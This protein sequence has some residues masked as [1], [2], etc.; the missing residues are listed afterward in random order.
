VGPTLEIYDKKRRKLQFLNEMKLLTPDL[1]GNIVLRKGTHINP[2]GFNSD[3]LHNQ[4]ENARNWSKYTFYPHKIQQER[5]GPRSPRNL[6]R[7]KRE[8]P[9]ILDRKRSVF[10]VSISKK[11]NF[12]GEVLVNNGAKKGFTDFV[13]D[14][15]KD[16]KFQKWKKLKKSKRKSNFFTEK[17]P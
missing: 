14:I 16:P 10:G 4:E 17:K 15:I 12:F 9:K 7:K 8:P 5:T 13:F 6:R 3:E 1:S 11:S 2:G